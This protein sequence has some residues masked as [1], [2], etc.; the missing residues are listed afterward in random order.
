MEDS[1]KVSTSMGAYPV[2]GEMNTQSEA[3]IVGKEIV[4]ARDSCIFILF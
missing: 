1:T 2:S 3:Q 4:Q